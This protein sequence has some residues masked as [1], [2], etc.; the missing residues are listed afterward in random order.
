M[1]YNL[2]VAVV[3]IICQSVTDLPLNLVSSHRQSETHSTAPQ[4]IEQDTDLEFD[5]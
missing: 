1:I 2:I 4:D 3:G 5:E